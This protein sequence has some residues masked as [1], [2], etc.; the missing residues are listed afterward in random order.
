M[1]YCK[2]GLSCRGQ[3]AVK[4]LVQQ[5]CDNERK[6]ECWR[7]RVPRQALWEM[8]K[9]IRSVRRQGTMLTAATAANADVRHMIPTH[10]LDTLMEV[11]CHAAVLAAQKRKKRGM[12]EK[13]ER[14][15]RKPHHASGIAKIHR[16]S[17]NT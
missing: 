10:L 17:N 15:R 11:R 12:C 13:Q 6:Q 9:Q 8:E 2:N 3:K 16:C 1:H 14:K 7:R 4:Q 5:H